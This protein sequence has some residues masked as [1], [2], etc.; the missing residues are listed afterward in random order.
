MPLPSLIHARP[1][2]IVVRALPT[3]VH[4]DGYWDCGGG[5][6]LAGATGSVRT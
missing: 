3:A 2:E 1:D 5:G 6:K 4:V